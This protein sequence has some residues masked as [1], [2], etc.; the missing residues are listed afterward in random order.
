M[1]DIG[2]DPEPRMP[3]IPR[4]LP[5]GK[6]N[7]FPSDDP[8][9]VSVSLPT[10]DSVIGLSRKEGW[11]LEKLA[12]SY[13]RF[14]LN[15]PVRDLADAVLRRLEITDENICC[16]V[17]NSAKA[18]RECASF[19]HT[20]SMEKQLRLEVVRFFMPAES[21]IKNTAGMHWANFSA[22]LFH[23]DLRKKA[24]CYWRDTGAG[25][26]TRH[27]SFC[28]EEFEYLDSDSVN[29]ALR[30]PAP[31]KREPHRQLPEYSTWI[32]NAHARQR[33]LQSI[34]ARLATSEQP[35]KLAVA[36]GDV[37]LYPNGMNAIYSLSESLASL[38]SDSQVVAYG[39]LYPE[40][41]EV[42]RQGAWKNVLSFKDGT[43]K[44]LDQLE[45]MLQSG[46]CIHSLF[47]E[48]PSNIK[49]SSPNLHRIRAL[50]DQ[51]GFIVACDDTV[52][53]YVNI[54]ALPYVDVMMS[55]LTKTFSGNSNV[56]GGSL[57]INPDS[58]YHAKIHAALSANYENTYFPLDLET[59]LHNCQ[60][61]AWR[62]RKCNQ[63]T[64]PLVDLLTKHPSIAQVNHPSIDPTAHLYKSLIREHGGY[65]NVLSIIFHHP[66]SA[67]HFYNVLDVCK[68]SS[69]GANFTLAIPY[70][71]LANYWDRDKVP[72]YGVPQHIIRISVGLEDSTELVR[73]VSR[74]L[75]EVTKLESESV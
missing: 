75:D 30:T 71:Q 37:F 70:V 59:L 33:E 44:E 28:L 53:G 23:G 5:L 26:S 2:R 36:P 32:Q 16:M 54:D 74:A 62:V 15:K 3:M 57:V 4:A 40:T 67:E 46:Q 13:P 58:R 42:L 56:T 21:N 64:L 22:V 14:Y 7:V 48:L 68:G 63:N 49:L 24:M 8:H 50:A 55:S 19:L 66:G 51:Y 73:T 69:F 60:S 52:A 20:E 10:W 18:G 9:A 6:A 72:K 61:V 11:V 27:A 1:G 17:V 35:G 25:L 12:C 38:W 34:I 31:K 43:E 45:S 39:W 29:A 65:G 41:V 47:C